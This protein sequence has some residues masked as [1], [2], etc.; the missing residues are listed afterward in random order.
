MYS[1]IYKTMDISNGLSEEVVTA[2]SIPI[3]NKKLNIYMETRHYELCLNPV[4]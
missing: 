2:T 1:F 3:M 4:T